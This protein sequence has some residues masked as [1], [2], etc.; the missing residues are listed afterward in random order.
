VHL[1]LCHLKRIKLDANREINEGAAGNADAGQA[2][3]EYHGFIDQA[4]TAVIA[5]DSRGLYV[6][7]HGHGHDKQ[8]LE[9]GY[10]LTASA[11]DVTDA[12]LD[13]GGALSTS[14]LHAAKPPATASTSA[15]LRGPTSLGGLLEP[16]FPA[17]PS[18]TNAS[19]GADPYFDGGYSTDRHTAK[20][21]GLQIE[22]N[23]AGVRDSATNRAAFADAL[24]SAVRTFAKQ[25]LGLTF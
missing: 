12:T 7:L 19:P 3:T 2:W 22:S 18:P 23:F 11:Y 5:R 13:A 25:H 8:R 20:L 14:S 17:V 6:D 15:L 1:I 16:Q 21:P 24:V 4:T 9:L 10:L